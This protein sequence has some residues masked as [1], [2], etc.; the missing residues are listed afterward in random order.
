VGAAWK[1]VLDRGLGLG[2]ADLLVLL[3]VHWAMEDNRKAAHHS[4]R[5]ALG[6]GW[7]GTWYEVHFRLAGRL[8]DMSCEA[9]GA[10]DYD[11]GRACAAAVMDEGAVIRQ[12]QQYVTFPNH[13]LRLFH[14]MQGVAELFLARNGGPDA[15][16]LL[17][18]ADNDLSEAGRHGD[19]SAEHFQYLA[20]VLVRR[21]ES[22]IKTGLETAERAHFDA[23]SA[24]LNRAERV[25]LQAAA[26]GADTR[27]LRAAAGDLAHRRGNLRQGVGD[28]THVQC[29]REALEHYDRAGELPATGARPDEVLALHRGQARY[30][31]VAASYAG[32]S[33]QPEA[34]QEMGSRPLD[35]MLDQAVVDLRV[36]ATAK[37]AVTFPLALMQRARKRLWCGDAH[38]CQEDRAEALEYVRSVG[39]LISSAD[40]FEPAVVEASVVDATTRLLAQARALDLELALRRGLDQADIALLEQ[41]L[42]QAAAVHDCRIH[43]GV[44]A[45]AAR[46]IA[47]ARS[48]RAVCELLMAV[49]VRLESQLVTTRS[50][51]RRAFVASHAATLAALS[52][53]VEAEL[54]QLR[55]IHGLYLQ[56][57]QDAETAD[58]RL[59]MYTAIAMLRLAKALTR[60]GEGRLEVVGLLRDA[61]ALFTVLVHEADPRQEMLTA[62][63]AEAVTE[64]TVEATAVLQ[65]LFHDADP[66]E[67][68][69]EVQGAAEDHLQL[70]PDEFTPTAAL[71]DEETVVD[72]LENDDE[73]RAE[74]RFAA[75]DPYLFAFRDGIAYPEPYAHW[76]Q[77]THEEADAW[78]AKLE[79]RRGEC[80]Y[81]LFMIEGDSSDADSAL[82]DFERSRRHGNNSAQLLGMVADIYIRRGRSSRDADQ[83]GAALALKAKARALG[84]H[85]REN[86]SVSAAAFAALHD[87]TAEAEYLASAV[88]CA[89]N[90]RAFAPEWPWPLFQLAE[91]S[92]M[93]P[94]ALSK[95]AAVLGGAEGTL[96]RLDETSVGLA[97]GVL[98]G[99]T[100]T[101]MEGAA[102]ALF[103]ASEFDRRGLGGKLRGHSGG[104]GVYVLAD[105]HRLLS[106]TVVVKEGPAE[107]ISHEA[108]AL[109]DLSA[110]LRRRGIRW[111]RIPE[112]NAL[113]PLADA[114]RCPEREMALVM[115]R[116]SGRP[117]SSL[118]AQ[119]LRSGEEPSEVL[120]GTARQ[121]MKALAYV[122]AWRGPAP[123]GSPRD[124]EASEW[125]KS[126]VRHLSS[127]HLAVTDGDVRRLVLDAWSTVVEVPLVGHRDAHAENWLVPAGADHRWVA[128][129]DLETST[130]SPA[131]YEVAQFLEDFPLLP[132]SQDGWRQ[133]LDL[134][135]HYLR[136]LPNEL[137]AATL[138]QDPEQLRHIYEVFALARAVFL[139]KHLQGPRTIGVS[140]G[141]RLMR[142]AR[143]KHAM[144]L[145]ASLSC[146]EQVPVA[147]LASIVASSDHQTRPS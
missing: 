17:I 69:V 4:L 134:T 47:F 9:F 15:Q 77:A 113:L 107:A 93:P 102:R 68:A 92:R 20:E 124:A 115:Q 30:R 80:Y 114:D 57:V 83:L 48:P 135:R 18:A 79:S 72:A 108:E 46:V 121:V 95:A 16:S 60:R 87:V 129:I 122:H 133:R 105:R 120:L 91:F 110:W 100:A 131:V 138:L 12:V 86:W 96:L 137:G 65:E 109:A 90:A 7:D 25:L 67:A 29:F 62:E 146:S 31:F 19:G 39:W 125:S 98:S 33:E 123:P 52:C 23:A 84:E 81:R 51:R 141:S 61:A 140:T 76:L 21:G 5:R 101:L 118:I 117:V 1:A 59:L 6:Y 71:I 38:G 103:A 63:T 32:G 94:G 56:A 144:S 34:G 14:G 147:S 64:A 13:K 66:T 139:L 50:A 54:E 143:L 10:K 44:L 58:P 11:L 3:L 104:D 111:V 26:T 112:V 78:A 82:S 2:P 132:V 24:H 41:Y 89:I 88:L 127:L 45:H 40:G 145:L 128:L 142:N 70:V 28:P 36:G 22:G 85:A 55:R 74:A 130:W 126:M 43:P 116:A 35:D 99:D 8:H 42:P 49:S 97:V 75:G 73:G 27:E 53:G 106:A 37:P 136:H 119:S